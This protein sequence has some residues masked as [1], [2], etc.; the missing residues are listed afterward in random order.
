M[1]IAIVATLIASASAFSV[2]KAAFTQVS[3][4]KS[5]CARA[6]G[7]WRVS[8]SHVGGVFQRVLLSC[9]ADVAPPVSS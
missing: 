4:Q 3:E 1:K 6:V 2:P 8:V 7:G 5:M 9:L